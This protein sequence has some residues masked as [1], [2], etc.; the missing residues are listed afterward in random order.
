VNILTK[1]FWAIDK[2]LHCSISLVLSLGFTFILHL[3]V[4]VNLVLLAMCGGFI[5]VFIGIVNEYVQRYL[6][7]RFED[8]DDVYADTIGVL[9]CIFICI[10]ITLIK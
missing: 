2:V 9:L 5:T 6:P 7:L 10:V 1:E 4:E 3:V 8:I